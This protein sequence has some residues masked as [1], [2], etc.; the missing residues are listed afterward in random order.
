MTITLAHPNC[1]QSVRG[2]FTI[3]TRK[4]VYQLLFNPF[5]FDSSDWDAAFLIFDYTLAILNKDFTA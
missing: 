1:G 2:L 3:S 5:Q 4:R